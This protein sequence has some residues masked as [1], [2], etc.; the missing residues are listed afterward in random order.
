MRT[1]DQR[2]TAVADRAN[3]LGRRATRRNDGRDENARVDDDPAHLSVGGASLGA[4][5]AE[6]GVR[7]GEGFVG[8]QQILGVPRPDPVEDLE[9]E[10]AS[11]RFL[12]H[13]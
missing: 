12:H 5:G 13:V 1:D 4:E 3:D 10:V 11:N 6:L 7:E 2:E 8:S 9:P